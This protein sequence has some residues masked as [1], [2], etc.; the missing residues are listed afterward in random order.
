MRQE[1]AAIVEEMAAIV[2]SCGVGPEAISAWHVKATYANDV[3]AQWVGAQ[4]Q[5]SEM[6]QLAHD[7][8]AWADRA[9]EAAGGDPAV[10]RRVKSTLADLRRAAP[11]FTG[12]PPPR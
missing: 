2:E 7:L 9:F 11:W 4:A 3:E 1:M 6:V 5:M 12:A 10:S 8:A